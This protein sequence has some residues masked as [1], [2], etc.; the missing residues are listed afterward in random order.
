MFQT[1]LV[2]VLIHCA[3]LGSTFF[4][5]TNGLGAARTALIVPTQPSL[6]TAL[7]IFLIGEK[8]RFIQ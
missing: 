4:A 2:G 3:F 5:M 7:A 8:P 1:A 6:T